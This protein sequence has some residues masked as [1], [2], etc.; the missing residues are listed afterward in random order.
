MARVDALENFLDTEDGANLLIAYR[1]AANILRIEEKK[2]GTRYVGEVSKSLFAE[3]EEHALHDSISEV[4]MRVER[5][6]AST[7]P[8]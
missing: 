1:R 5:S 6:L 8:S 2:D 3:R 7:T 4:G